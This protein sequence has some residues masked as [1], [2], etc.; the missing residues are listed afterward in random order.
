MARPN[1][2][3]YRELESEEILTNLEIPT[4]YADGHIQLKRQFW[5]DQ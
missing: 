3:Q 4:S 2:R 1:S 5:E